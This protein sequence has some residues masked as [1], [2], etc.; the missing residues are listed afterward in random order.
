MVYQNGPPWFVYFATFV[1]VQIRHWTYRLE[2]C[3]RVVVERYR[4]LVVHC[5][6]S[7]GRC[8]VRSPR[9][10]KTRGNGLGVH[11][12]QGN[13]VRVGC[14]IDRY[15]GHHWGSANHIGCEYI[16]VVVGQM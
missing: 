5:L 2:D 9:C 16:G 10:P 12:S 7:L 8:I 4:H 13:R 1:V 14:P 15:T 6:F 11:R 3:N